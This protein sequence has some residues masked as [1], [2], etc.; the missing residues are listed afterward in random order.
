MDFSLCIQQRHGTA[1]V[2]VNNDSNV[3]IDDGEAAPLTLLDA[4]AAF[5]TINH[6]LLICGEV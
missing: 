6:A 1:L 3:N 2:K 5:Y 4:S